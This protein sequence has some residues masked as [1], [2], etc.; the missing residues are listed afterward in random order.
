M[1]EYHGSIDMT[2]F[3]LADHQTVTL[4]LS[5]GRLDSPMLDDSVP[6]TVKRS[7]AMSLPYPASHTC[8]ICG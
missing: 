1:V 5:P 3:L 4:C 8:L 2:S 6:T 7:L